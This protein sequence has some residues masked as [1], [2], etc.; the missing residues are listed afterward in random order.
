MTLTH[1]DFVHLHTHSEYSMLD[2]AN[3]LR[4]L[5]AAAHEL[6]MPALALTDHGAMHG[7]IEFYK[8]AHRQGV[9]PILGCEVYVT[10]GS[11]FDRTPTSSG[12][13]A[14]HH[15][16]LLAR[17]ETGYRNLMKLTSRAFLEGFY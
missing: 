8:E 13:A 15:L 3:R 7:C 11:R 14:T 10:T 6:R 2:G 16:V 5:V 1:C 4:D 12:G 9:K 17:D